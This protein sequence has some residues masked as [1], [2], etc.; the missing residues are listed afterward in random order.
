MNRE[1]QKY[2]H[3]LNTAKPSDSKCDRISLIAT[4]LIQHRNKILKPQ[5]GAGTDGNR[6]TELLTKAFSFIKKLICVNYMIVLLLIV[7][8]SLSIIFHN[9]S[10][11]FFR[12]LCLLQH[13]GA[14]RI[15]TNESQDLSRKLIRTVYLI[16]TS[17][18]SHQDGVK[19][20][21]FKICSTL[22]TRQT[23]PDVL[24]ELSLQI[25]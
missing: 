2:T 1:T 10:P 3:Q 4:L 5:S 14:G 19:D 20:S 8:F 7:S 17:H 11:R 15:K 12:S 21:W 24:W 16:Y 9:H 25:P 23:A 6:Q 18:Y 13:F 22:R